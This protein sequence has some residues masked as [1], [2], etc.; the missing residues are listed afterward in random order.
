MDKKVHPTL[1]IVDDDE[2]DRALYKRFLRRP[3]GTQ[4]YELFEATSGRDAIELYESLKPD[5]VLLD[6]KLPDMTG[7]DVLQK[8]GEMTTIL[9]VVMLTGQG[10]EDIAASTFKRGAQDYIT[11]GVVTPAGLQR[12]VIATMDRADLLRRVDQQNKELQI[13]KE[14]AERADRA[15]GEFL[16]TMSHEIRTPMNGIVGMADLLLYTE[17]T[18]MQTEYVN[19]IRSSCTLLLN[20]INDILDFSKIEAQELVLEERPVV[21]DRVLTEVIQLLGRR[22]HENR[23]EIILRWPRDTVIPTILA[24]P[25]RLR[26]LLI[27]IVGN[28]IKFTHDGTVTISILPMLKTAEVLG[29]RV[30]V[31]DTGIGIPA[32][33]LDKIF[34][35]FTQVDSSTTREYGG[36][37]LGLAISKRLVELMDGVIGVESEVNKGSL[38]WF[39]IA[40]RVAGARE[41]AV[42]SAPLPKTNLTGKTI[43]IVNDYQENLEIFAAYLEPTGATTV[44]ASSAFE[45][46]EMLQKA[47]AQ[48]APFDVVLADDDLARLDGEALCRKIG[49]DPDAYGQPKGM[50]VSAIGRRM[51]EATGMPGVA[52]QILKPVFPATLVQAV[53]QVISG[54]V[55]SAVAALSALEMGGED[56]PVVL[57]QFGAHVLVVEDDRVSQRL[58]K[59]V[60]AQLGCTC[61]VA[62]DGREG[63]QILAHQAK[64]YDIVF[65]DWQMPVMDGHDAIRAIR[66][67]PWGR[68]LKIVALTANAIHG[69]REACL[70]VGA[71][72]YLSKPVRVADVIEVLGR[73]L[74]KKAA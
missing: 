37:G 28:A 38:F 54:E 67:E 33:K 46:L 41:G 71:D 40:V 42:A 70:R 57:S 29:L 10:S 43:L 68:P 45:A 26:Q 65:M 21:L 1:L 59:S 12:A 25:M 7:L 18:E 8:I 39:N 63:V 74:P 24:D 53:S 19:T 69:D 66:A 23:V 49:D 47:K 9:P 14:R 13:A 60:L 17:L 73:Q 52:L 36:T 11:K 31:Q 22:A 44:T 16:A 2:A 30:E 72:D 3:D 51:R 27:N 4:P 6:Y 20:I 58:A 32:D 62:G 5:C 15:K 64:R 50:L 35:K 56:G 55:S 61:D 48:G 34:G